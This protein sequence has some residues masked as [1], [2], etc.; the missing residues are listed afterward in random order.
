MFFSEQ[1]HCGTF[2]AFFLV[3]LFAL[4]SA[5]TQVD[6]TTQNDF[7][8]FPII[9]N[10]VDFWEKIYSTYSLNTAVI[11]DQNDLTKIYAV[12]NL[13]DKDIPRARSI[14]NNHLETI[15]E[16]YEQILL[17]LSSGHPPATNEEQRVA[18]M[19]QGPAAQRT[20]RFAAENIRAQ[21]GQK[22]RFLE[23]T[24]RST[25]YIEKIKKIFHE[26]GLP[27]DLAYLPHVES[28]F[29]IQAYS[30]CGA[31]GI[32]QFTRSTGKQ[33]M[34]ID[35][36]TDERRDPLIST[37]AA[38]QLLKKNYEALGSWPLAI[39]AYNYGTAGMVRAAQSH[40]SYENIFRHYEEG[41]FKFASRNF[42][43][44]FLAARKVAKELSGR[45]VQRPEVSETTRS[46]S[47]TGSAGRETASRNV[48]AVP[49]AQSPPVAISPSAVKSKKHLWKR[50]RL[51]IYTV[52]RGDTAT[53]IAAS[54]NIS[55]HELCR[56]NNLNPKAILRSGQSLRIPARDSSP[57]EKETLRSIST[58]GKRS[59]A[60]TTTTKNPLQTISES[61]TL[62]RED[63]PRL[64]VQLPKRRC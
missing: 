5:P 21:N 31:A 2:R 1:T 53:S 59:A 57:R 8:E 15:K 26:Y 17:R 13:V 42:Y 62:C 46:S 63:L 23:G 54:A 25:R 45:Y 11:H 51:R 10:N 41:Y 32:W 22:E 34:R 44:E 3:F 9:R 56:E 61:R 43:S 16:K 19:F 4:L 48:K 52:K 35:R 29:N 24:L 39:T 64:N 40:G 12:V 58:P 20:M 38:A 14:N 27:G 49:A 37:R 30:K 55:V 28:S 50:P 47:P 18:R 6:A 36:H 60:A 7:P 33:Y